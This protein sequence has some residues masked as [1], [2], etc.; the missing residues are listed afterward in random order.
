MNARISGLLTVAL[1]GGACVPSEGPLMSPN[2]D[3][4]GC[5]GGGGD[6]KTWTVAGTFG[7]KGSRIVITD[8]GGKTLTLRAAQNGNFYTAEGVTFPLTVTVDGV[9]MA[10][11][12]DGQVVPVTYGGCN[13][14]HGPGGVLTT[15]PDM[16]P[17]SDCL[18]C[19]NGTVSQV[20]F[21]AAGTWPGATRVTVNGV[22]LTRAPGGANFY[23]NDARAAVSSQR[24]GTASVDGRTME[25]ALTYGGCGRCHGA[26]GNAGD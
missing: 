16:G 10:R 9:P 18:A 24:P 1:L 22:S 25:P 4:L 12:S 20:A 2:Q 26:G 7:G 13:A 11:K 3:C 8:A 14:C 23:T 6:G 21:T 19:H 5:H 15:G 17:G